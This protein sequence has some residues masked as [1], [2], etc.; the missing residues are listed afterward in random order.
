MRAVAFIALM[1]EPNPSHTLAK[2]LTGGFSMARRTSLPGQY[3]RHLRGTNFNPVIF[4]DT[5]GAKA[6]TVDNGR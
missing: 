3:C 4:E 1:F 2:S 6:F 5:Q